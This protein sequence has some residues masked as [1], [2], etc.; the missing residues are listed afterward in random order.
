MTTDPFYP[1]LVECAFA[2]Q[3]LILAGSGAL[4][5]MVPEKASLPASPRLD[6]AP[7]V[8]RAVG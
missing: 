4:M 7:E 2:A 5:T 6:A 3:G 1:V 8:V